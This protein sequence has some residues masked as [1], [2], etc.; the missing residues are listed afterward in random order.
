V[1][2]GD[3]GEDRMGEGRTGPCWPRHPR[4]ITRAACLMLAR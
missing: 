4:M 3:S 2:P 1:L